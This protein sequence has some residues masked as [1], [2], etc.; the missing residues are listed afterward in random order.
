MSRCKRDYSRGGC[1]ECKRRKIKCD[2]TKP[3]CLRC[4]RLSKQC[5]YPGRGETVL[6]VS[7][8]YLQDH[9]DGIDPDDNSFTIQ[10][11]QPKAAKQRQQLFSLKPIWKGPETAAKQPPT[12]NL[13]GLDNL[14]DL[15]TLT[16]PNPITPALAITSSPDPP[17]SGVSPSYLFSTEDLHSLVTDANLMVLDL[18]PDLDI[19][20]E[21][22]IAFTEP[23]P[24]VL[25]S[26]A[27]IRGIPAE[28]M[29]RL[30]LDSERDY[31]EKFFNEFG[32]QIFPFGCFDL[33]TNG[34]INPLR[35][36][37]L[38]YALR[39]P[40][41]LA[42]VLALGAKCSYEYLEKEQPENPLLSSLQDRYWH[43]L[44]QC[45]KLLGPALTHNQEKEVKN[46]MVAN[47]ELIL[48][49]VLLLALANA[50][51]HRHNWRPHLK[52]AK[53]ILIKATNS[54]I[55]QL[56][57]LILC[58]MW[59]VDF[60]ILAGTS[61]A[62]GG[63]LTTEFELDSVLLFSN[64]YEI[65]VLRELGIIEENGFNV[66]SGYHYQMIGSFKELLKLLNKQKREGLGFIANESIT[67]LKLL[68][69]FNEFYNMTYVN[70][71]G[72]LPLL[73]VA[74]YVGPPPNL[75]DVLRG[76]SQGKEVTV[77]LSWMDICQQVYLLAA[78]ITILTWILRLPFDMP[79]V[80]TLTAKLI[81]LVLWVIK[82]DSLPSLYHR[83]LFLMIHWPMIIAGLNCVDEDH[84]IIL[85]KYFSFALELGLFLAD[86]VRRKLGDVWEGR[87]KGQP[88]D[89][90]IDC[91]AY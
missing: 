69:T 65:V 10:Y 62:L 64:N 84:K 54:K 86:L 7:K 44:S 29:T 40:Y 48:L 73:F 57:T 85:M 11:Y 50:L 21:D 41:L 37:I 79:F 39:E 8:Q 20:D 77:V 25:P 42:A 51:L 90:G 24:A 18:L 14:A 13:S 56:K 89:E 75:V 88:V 12:A 17:P 15:A 31:M 32:Q 53:D 23:P 28:Y 80:Q 72:I 66:F 74:N 87:E 58:K 70:R 22:L 60:E 2:E 81:A 47:L 82:F 34:Y 59:F 71:D 16:L 30:G 3:H 19:N 76:T 49:T 4:S 35:D 63:T 38:R 55:R 26:T 83:Y 27:T 52:G 36:C 9:A 91:L 6:R 46:D 5:S 33:A 45:L 1:R 67:Y 78:V 43:Y 68:S 61:L